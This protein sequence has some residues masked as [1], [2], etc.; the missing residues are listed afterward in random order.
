MKST[1]WNFVFSRTLGPA[2]SIYLLE[3]KHDLRNTTLITG[4]NDNI[5]GMC[6]AKAIYNKLSEQEE[7]WEFANVVTSKFVPPKVF[8]LVWAAMHDSVPTRNMLQNRRVI[9]KSNL[10]L[11]CNAQVESQDHLFVNCK[12]VNYF[13]SSFLKSINVRWVFNQGIKECLQSWSLNRVCERL[14]LVWHSIPFAICWEMWLERN[15][16]VHGGRQK[17]TDDLLCD[18]KLDIRL[19]S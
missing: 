18:M 3:I 10:C 11:F 7:N 16:R 1:T 6:T 5:E 2:E 12:W 4:E 9:V 15:S 17:T 13:W 8:F 14:K 19:W